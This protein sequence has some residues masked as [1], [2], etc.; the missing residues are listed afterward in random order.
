MKVLNVIA[1]Q[2]RNLTITYQTDGKQKKQTHFSNNLNNKTSFVSIENIIKKVSSSYVEEMNRQETTTGKLHNH[3]LLKA[4]IINNSTTTSDYE[5]TQSI[6]N[7]NQKDKKPETEK[8]E[9]TASMV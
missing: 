6:M 4:T 8:E 3:Q 9:Y 5:T 1:V 2:I 7:C